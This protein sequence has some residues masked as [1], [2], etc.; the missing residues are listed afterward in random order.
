MVG[1]EVIGGE[2]SGANEEAWGG[3]F[4]TLVAVPDYLVAK[5]PSNISLI[6][7]ALLP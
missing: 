2:D 6:E 1:D 4:Q 5:K 3:S 7:A